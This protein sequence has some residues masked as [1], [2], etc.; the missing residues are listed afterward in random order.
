MQGK[1]KALTPS[2]LLPC[3]LASEEREGSQ[4]KYPHAGVVSEGGP[5][6]R[7]GALLATP[8]CDWARAARGAEFIP[9]ADARTL[10]RFLVNT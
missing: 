5:V 3:T 2:P 7:V 1:Q 8:G 4:C 10:Y 6:N 9:A